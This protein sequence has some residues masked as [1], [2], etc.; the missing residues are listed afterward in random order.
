MTRIQEFRNCNN[1]GYLRNFLSGPTGMEFLE[2]LKESSEPSKKADAK[3]MASGQDFVMQ[4]ALNHSARIAQFEMISL[5]KE[6]ANPSDKANAPQVKP[7]EGPDLEPED[8]GDGMPRKTKRPKKS[9][10]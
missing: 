5:I 10:S 3:Q 8:E 9:Q 6:L 4:L 7:E 2:I 1:A